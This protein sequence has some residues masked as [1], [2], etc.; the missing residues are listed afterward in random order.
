MHRRLI[1]WALGVVLAALFAACGP[2]QYVSQVTIRAKKRVA[3][4]K[5]QKA[6]LYAKYEY[7]HADAYLEQAKHRA[8]F[9]DFQTSYRYGKHAAKMALK[10][11][12]LAK[13]RRAEEGDAGDRPTPRRLPPPRR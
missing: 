7:F 11:S 6:D 2:I 4:A 5:L 10:A 13:E 8:G 3:D 9:G 1:F 12:K